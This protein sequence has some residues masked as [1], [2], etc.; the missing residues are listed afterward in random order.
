LPPKEARK[1]EFCEDTS[2]SGKGLPPSALLLR[3][4]FYI[5]LTDR[6]TERGNSSD[7]DIKRNVVAN[8]VLAM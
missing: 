1:K 3:G 6:T 4:F 5:A 2:H 7:K 8:R